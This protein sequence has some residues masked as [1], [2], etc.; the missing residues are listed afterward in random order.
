[1]EN[2]EQ[3]LTVE[4]AA[5]ILRLKVPELKLMLKDG[6]I[7]SVRLSERKWRVRRSVVDGLINGQTYYKDREREQNKHDSRTTVEGNLQNFG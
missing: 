5:L 2:E 6:I 4:E 1:M 3:L 7:P